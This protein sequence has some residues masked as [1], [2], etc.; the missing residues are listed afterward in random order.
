MRYFFLPLYQHHTHAYN[1]P[2]L[3]WRCRWQSECAWWCWMI[4]VYKI[5][6]LAAHKPTVA[7]WPNEKSISPVGIDVEISQ[8][9]LDVRSKTTSFQKR[10]LYFTLIYNVFF[11]WSKQNVG[12]GHKIFC[13]FISFYSYTGPSWPSWL[14]VLLCHCLDIVYACNFR[15][16]DWYVHYNLERSVN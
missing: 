5:D 11:F 7:R 13:R 14:H 9:L 6:Q 16:I 1:K 3:S 12:R 8:L 4:L 10:F 15:P 2:R